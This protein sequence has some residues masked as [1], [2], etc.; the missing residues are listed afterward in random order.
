MKG[1]V[2]AAPHGRS[3]KTTVA[4]GLCAA[5]RR[6]GLRVQP[7]KK[8]PD[9][10]DPGWLT[11]AAGRPCRNLDLF[12]LG[13]ELTRLS[14]AQSCRG[15]EVALVEGAMGI[16]DGLDLAGSGSTA[17]LARALGL[18]VVLLLDVSRMTRTAAAIVKGLLGFEADLP[19]V[20]VI[21]NRVGRPRQEELVRAA[22]EY[23]TG[24]PVLGAIPRW[25]GAA[26]PDRHLGL[27]PVAERVALQDPWA[28]QA[29]EEAAR[30]V[31][32]GVELDRLL[33]V[34]GPPSV[35]TRALPLSF[36]PPVP[37]SAPPA[38]PEER[39]PVGVAQDR[40]FHF[41]YPENLEALER[42]GA[43]LVRIDCLRERELPPVAALYLGGGFPEVF[44]GEL[45]ANRS[46]RASLREAIRRG[47]PVYAECGGLMYLARALIWR[48]RSWEMVGALPFAVEM[49]PF[50]RGHGYVEAEVVAENPYFPAGQVVRG[51]EFH[52][53]LP[54][55][56]PAGAL[57]FR[58]RRGTG[59]GQGWDGLRWGNVF[60]SYLHVHALA[61]P[62]WAP[63]LVGQARAYAHSLG[64]TRV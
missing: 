59:C 32:S 17:Q 6:R 14:F 57:V 26:V 50:P 29:V 11:L 31:E 7:F 8:G 3:G 60:A 28:E 44:A 39:V 24:V 45:E 21:L 54:L 18:P 51:H 41:Y 43:E 64:G 62:G 19:L 56:V 36:L 58:L 61:C 49:A 47:L 30:A 42:A 10:I 33:E 55:E 22:M 53:S 16:F 20:G 34:A 13:E 27:V 4:M 37:P 23:H 15:A 2:L 63:A 46:L 38:P 9:F 52:Y 12:L 40:A 35:D 48:G 5:W 25:A 1:L